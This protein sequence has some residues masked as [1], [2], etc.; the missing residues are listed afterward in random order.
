[1]ASRIVL[2]RVVRNVRHWRIDFRYVAAASAV[3]LGVLIMAGVRESYTGSLKQLTEAALWGLELG[4]LL[5]VAARLLVPLGGWSAKEVVS[6]SR[7]I[8]YGGWAIP[9][10]FVLSI[11]TA[12]VFGLIE[13]G[14]LRWVLT[15]FFFSGALLAAWWCRWWL[16]ARPRVATRVTAND[17]NASVKK[18][19]LL[20]YLIDDI[21]AAP[22]RGV[23]YP[24]ADL[25]KLVDATSKVRENP[26]IGSALA[27]LD[28]VVNVAPWQ[29]EVQELGEASALID[30]RWN[31]ERITSRLI[32][33]TRER[34]PKDAPEALEQMAAAVVATA[35][36]KRYIDW[37]GLYGA[38]I[39]RSV[40]LQLVARGFQGDMRQAL[41]R[42]AVFADDENV[43]AR[44]ALANELNGDATRKED[45]QGYL[46]NLERT[47]AD[48]AQRG[49]RR[50]E[51][52]AETGGR[53]VRPDPRK[54][55]SQTP[56]RTLLLR[57][58]IVWATITRNLIA[59]VSA[60]PDEHGDAGQIRLTPGEIRDGVA[61][62]Q[63]LVILMHESENDL[64]DP[65][66]ERLLARMRARTAISIFIL[67]EAQIYGTGLS[68]LTK[69]Q[70][71]RTWFACA[72]KSDDPII[73]H[74]FACYIA[75]NRSFSPIP[76]DADPDY[77]NSVFRQKLQSALSDASDLEW[78]RQDPEL[79]NTQDA[80]WAPLHCDQPTSVWEVEPLKQHQERLAKVGVRTVASLAAGSES[81]SAYL[82]LDAKEYRRLKK[83]ASLADYLELHTRGN[84]KQPEETTDEPRNSLQPRCSRVPIVL[85]KLVESGVE[86]VADLQATTPEKLSEIL[87]D[88]LRGV[89]DTASTSY[90]RPEQVISGLQSDWKLTTT[91]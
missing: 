41:L 9:A 12:G 26:F 58:L 74:E 71:V 35:M 73:A 4:A 86:T 17:G 57:T 54:E 7:L 72:A 31:G 83:I 53:A 65:R 19:A 68:S 81:I 45:L 25:N 46:A 82:G 36:A 27:F 37:T 77:L 3:A 24:T 40:G 56:P 80:Y 44:F 8:R 50:R 48:L 84:Y 34:L 52:F 76:P 59:V 61:A 1:M 13:A 49:Q 38:T 39:W 22:A 66:Q 90:L 75:R 85:K 29:V 63:E 23:E 30:V 10:V 6:R 20:T 16:G 62:L 32:D 14:A 11:L 33:R 64:D 47:A 60:V 28:W 89:W 21:G 43:L 5:I 79:Q 88:A 55:S 87:D 2:Q 70:D 15:W 67:D 51:L 18:S 91:H 69:D 42:R 78:A